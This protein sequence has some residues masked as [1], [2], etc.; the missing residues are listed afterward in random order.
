MGYRSVLTSIVLSNFFIL[1][2]VAILIVLLNITKYSRFTIF[3][4]IFL[5]T[6]LEIFLGVIYKVIQQSVFLK[7]WIGLEIPR[8]QTIH[9]SSP[10]PR[11]FLDFPRDFQLLRESVIEESSAVAFDWI[12]DHLTVIDPKNLFISTTSRFNLINHPSD[13]YTG[14][15]NLHPINDL[16]RINKFFETVNSKL[17]INGI[18][19]GCC[20]TYSLRKR[21][22]LR[23]FPPVVN[24]FVYTIDFIIFRV[25]PKLKLTRKIYFL[26]TRGRSRVMSRTETLGRLYSCGF[27]VMEEKTIGNLLYWK[28]RKIDLPCFD[29]NPT[30]GILIRLHRIGKDGKE[31][32]VFKFRTMH[33]YAEYVQGY[34]H[35]KNDLEQGGKFKDDFRVTTIGR[36]MRK[37]WID[38]LPM[39]FN[40]FI[41]RNMSLVGVR[42]LS[43]HYFNLY[44]QELR[45]KRIK[46]KP[47]LIPPYYAQFPTPKTLEEIQQNELDYLKSYEKHPFRSDVRYFFKA[48]YNILIKRARSK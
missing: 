30:Y 22:I 37:F 35:Q 27:E 13:F 6:I 45:E 36:F 16:Q 40:V 21:K 39:L 5:A 1:A 48:M 19:I 23:R 2:A 14:I 20:E 44:C 7:D 47:G 11:E 46:Y 17:P 3:G 18:L 33:A 26:F 15:I 25:C 42:P 38:E 43:K 8:E 34:I 9:I 29:C 4:S 31:F 10:P 41:R 28:C 32:N 24:Y 12:N